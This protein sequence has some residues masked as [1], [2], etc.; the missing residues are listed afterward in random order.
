MQEKILIIILTYIIIIIIFGLS[1]NQIKYISRRLN[2][3]PHHSEFKMWYMHTCNN[4]AN[5]KAN[6]IDYNIRMYSI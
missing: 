5:I 2:N 1:I 4:L 6:I 3:L